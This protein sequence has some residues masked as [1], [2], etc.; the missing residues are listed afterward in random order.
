MT[1]HTAGRD[2]F[3]R[4]A[5]LGGLFYFATVVIANLLRFNAVNFFPPLAD[6]TY[7]EITST[8]LSAARC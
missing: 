1:D 2:P 3:L 7:E 8:T 5:G 4:I 6:A